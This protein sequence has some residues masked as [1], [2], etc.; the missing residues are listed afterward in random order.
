MFSMMAHRRV[1]L[2]A[3]SAGDQAQTVSV[4]QAGVKR[5]DGRSFEIVYA[6]NCPPAEAKATPARGPLLET[7]PSGYHRPGYYRPLKAWKKKLGRQAMGF[8]F[9]DH[10]V[11]FR[12]AR[13]G[14]PPEVAAQQENASRKRNGSR[15][16]RGDEGDSV[17]RSPPDREM[18]YK[19][20][21]SAVS[22]DKVIREALLAN[23]NPPWG[24]LCHTK[25]SFGAILLVS[26]TFTPS[27]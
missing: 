8:R 7:C 20:G 12:A 11:L 27:T 1:F 4:A 21:V 6:G 22:Y 10:G 24:N 16:E 26:P 13:A 17:R 23:K 3:F 5:V 25:S 2:L 18:S 14:H 15:A 9:Q 19:K